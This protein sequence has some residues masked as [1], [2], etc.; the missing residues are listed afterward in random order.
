[1]TTLTRKQYTAVILAYTALVLLALG[2]RLAMFDRYLPLL[3]YPDESNMFLLSVAMRGAGEVPLAE[4]YG[5]FVQGEWLAG[6]PPLYPWLGVWAQRLTEAVTDAFLFPGD[7]MVG[8]RVLSVAANVLTVTGLLALGWSVA[9]PLG[10]GWAALSGW[11]AALPYA[12]S[13][14]V[15][16]IGVL[17]IPDSLIPLACVIALLGGVRAITQDAPLWLVWSLLGAIAA[18]YLKYSLFVALWP[19]ACGVVVLLRRDWRRM[20]PWLGTG[21]R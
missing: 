11:F 21:W 2:L 3:D 5:A 8:L 20:L 18:I 9:R 6:Y 16:D 15:I 12:L 10:A 13:P 14:Q 17:A 1:M 4:Q 19:T 7:Y